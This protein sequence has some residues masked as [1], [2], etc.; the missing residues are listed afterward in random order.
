[1]VQSEPQEG[2]GVEE[3]ERKTRERKQREHMGTKRPR[4]EP[5]TKM[6]EV[7]KGRKALGRE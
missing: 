7:T 1:M 6:A 3:G 5:G 2:E 4:V